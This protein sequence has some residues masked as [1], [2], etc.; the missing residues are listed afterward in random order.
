MANLSQ[1]DRNI[2]AEHSLNKCLNHLQDSLRKAKQDYK[3]RSISHD[4]TVN[5]LNSSSQK[6]ISRLLSTLQDQEVALDLH[7]KIENSNVATKLSKLFELVQGDRYNYEQYRALSRPVIKQTS[8][9]DI[10][11]VVFD[12]ITR[13]SQ[14]TPPTSIPSSFDG[15][16]ITISSSSFQGS[17]QT[18]KIIESTIFYEIKGCTYRNVDDFFEKYFERRP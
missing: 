7:S 5:S 17:E 3:P 18:R 4:S 14:T 11:S 10:W 15:T 9:V 8:D 12:L 2:I 16:P 1:N 13:V 6:A